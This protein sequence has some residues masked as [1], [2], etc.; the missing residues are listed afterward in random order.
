MGAEGALVAG[1][2]VGTLVDIRDEI[3]EAVAG[4]LVG[5]ESALVGAKVD[6]VL[7]ETSIEVI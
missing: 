3:G 1:E 4:V 5:L 2:L 7:V 6:G